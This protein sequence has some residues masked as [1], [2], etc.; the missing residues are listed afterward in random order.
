MSWIEYKDRSR[1]VFICIILLLL[2]IVVIGAVGITGLKR[3]RSDSSYLYNNELVPAMDMAMV[4]ERLY[5]N[6]FHLEEHISGITNQTLLELEDEMVKNNRSIDSLIK[7]YLD[8]SNIREGN[9]EVMKNINEKIRAYRKIEHSVIKDSRAGK[10]AEAT[11]RYKLES[12]TA[13]QKAVNPILSYSNSSLKEGKELY[14]DSL[15]VSD[16]VRIVLYVFISL[17]FIIVII[18]GIIISRAYLD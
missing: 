15:E 11:D 13:F 4:L 16:N 14:E 3:L 5:L 8:I 10:K 18:I 2:I 7:I 6:R 12:Y 1:I 17:A 9:I